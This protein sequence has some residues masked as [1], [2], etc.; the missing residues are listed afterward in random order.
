MT[1]V[2]I[3][4]QYYHPEGP[5]PTSLAE[6]LAARGYAVEVLTAFPHYLEGRIYGG[7][8]QRLWLREQI[9]GIPVTRLPLYASHDNSSARRCL[10]YGTFALSASLLGR[11]VARRPHVIYVHCPPITVG[12]AA[13]AIRT[14]GPRVPLVLHVQDLWPEGAA[15]HR[16]AS[17]LGLVDLIRRVSR[18][19]YRSADRILAISP[20][21]KRVIED[22]GVPPD[23]VEVLYNWCQDEASIPTAAAAATTNP[24]RSSP[25]EFVVSY[26][27]NMGPVQDLGTVLDAAAL[28]KS[29]GEPVRFVLIGDGVQRA[30][31]ETRCAHDGLTN[32]TFLPRCSFAEAVRICATCDA[33]LVHLAAD[34]VYRVWIPS[35]TQASLA[36]GRPILI[37]VEGD[38]RDLVLAAGAGVPFRPGDPEALASAVQQLAAAPKSDREGMGRMARAYYQA[39]LSFPVA[40]D[41]IAHVIDELAS[42]TRAGATRG[43]SAGISAQHRNDSDE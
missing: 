17:R 18:R 22:Y 34:D 5:I 20:G 1:R 21:F 35:K 6:G 2:L 29:R 23:R 43:S 30:D 41:R 37:G 11:V 26:A 25:Q 3:L 15:V 32:I 14:F 7:Y 42:A 16:M 27:G 39:H 33:S 4:S 24:L 12:L 13:L 31:L 8:R 9:N 10:T 28:L 36:L 19:V 38:A 40:C